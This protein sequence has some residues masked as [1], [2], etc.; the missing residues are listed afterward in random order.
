MAGEKHMMMHVTDALNRARNA[1]RARRTRAGAAPDHGTDPRLHEIRRLAFV[2]VPLLCLILLNSLLALRSFSSV[3]ERER[4][5]SHTH[6]VEAQI[7]TVATTLSDA[8][9]GQRGYLLTGDATYL[10]PYTAARAS[11]D[12][13]VAQLQALTA[14]DAAQQ[15]RASALKPLIAP[16]LA[17]LQRAIELRASGRSDAA[18]AV[19]SA[20]ADKRMVESVRALLAEM[21]GAEEQLLDDRLRAASGSLTEAQV[22]MLVATL[23][24]VALLAAL[25]LL[26]RRAFAVREQHLRRER[27]ARAAAEA[28]VTLR[29]QF[30]SIA[31]HELRTPLTAL[32]N[33]VQLIE[34]GLGGQ[35]GPD[36]R[37]RRG[38]AAIHRQLTR[39]GALI[40]TMLDVSRIDRG[41]LTIAREP[42][43]LA[44]LVRGV[45]EDMRLTA[46][47]RPIELAV[48]AVPAVLADAPGAIRVRGDA[49]RLE[50]VLLNLL[51]NAIKYS[52]DGGPI[53]VEVARG[54]DWAA[55]A[56]TDHGLGIQRE[57]LPHLFE[58]FYRAP[59]V[60]SE[61]ISGMG[62]GLYV[63]R[64][65][66][67]LHG[68]KIT[69]ASTEGAGSTFT[70]RLP[71]I[72][73]DT[74]NAPERDEAA[75]GAAVI[76][77]SHD[78]GNP[79]A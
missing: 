26:L 37:Y 11:I 2:F 30:L 33:N 59:A 73:P 41:Q 44:A 9:T 67:S 28:A 43:D 15:R 42:L 8:E 78:V 64:E 52:P 72:A 49:L 27:Q 19:M 21:N 76:P 63:V 23:A 53:Q 70:V 56:V 18:F 50:Q 40:A 1:L 68:G 61:H 34:R 24:N 10:A 32:L 7:A 66:V 17:E 45:V 5:V 35:L 54:A 55:V 29:D 20:A 6:A 4:V 14:G 39:L 65:I 46:G 51:Q 31:S 38:F 79:R 75:T 74:P 22:T 47:A 58:R 3:A 13:Q 36:E 48:P 77:A 60:T 71:L 57:A 25:F 16:L 62:I 12:T 69:V